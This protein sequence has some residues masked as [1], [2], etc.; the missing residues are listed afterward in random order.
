MPKPKYAYTGVIK[1]IRV[2][3]GLSWYIWFDTKTVLG[4]SFTSLQGSLNAKIYFF[5]CGKV[6][7]TNR[8]MRDVYRTM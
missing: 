5:G 8:Y 7:P 4:K 1:M 2:T 3:S 6:Y